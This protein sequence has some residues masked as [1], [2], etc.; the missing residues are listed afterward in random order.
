MKDFRNGR[1]VQQLADDY[2]LKTEIVDKIFTADGEE[3]LGRYRNRLV[4]LA[5]SIKE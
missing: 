4:E 5:Q 2:G 3:A 1:T